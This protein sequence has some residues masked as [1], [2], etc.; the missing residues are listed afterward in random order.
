MKTFLIISCLLVSLQAGEGLAAAQELKQAELRKATTSGNA[1]RLRKVIK[2]VEKVYGGV[3]VDARAFQADRVYYRI[4]VKKPNG[5]IISVIVNAQTGTVVPNHSQIGKQISEAA[6][7]APGKSV[8]ADAP[9]KSGT[10]GNSGGNNGNGNG[11]GGNNSGGNGGGNSG[12]N[13]GGNSGGNGGGNSG[14]NGGG[15]GGGKGGGK[16]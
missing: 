12:G 11:N 3:P 8:S 7:T 16:K 1:I 13:G 6:R 2:G 4:L 10:K 9:G 14:G 15:N 5:K